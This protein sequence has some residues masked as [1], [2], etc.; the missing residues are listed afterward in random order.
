M[1]ADFKYSSGELKLKNAVAKGINLGLLLNGT[2]DINQQ[3]FKIKGVSIPSYLINTV[4]SHFPFV[5]WVL[6]GKKGLLSSE[7][8]VTGPWNDSK[9]TTVPLSFFKLGFLKNIPL[10]KKSKKSKKKSRVNK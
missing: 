3:K 1:D 5:G 9:I 4:F 2:V 10:F 8:T 6:G 7:F